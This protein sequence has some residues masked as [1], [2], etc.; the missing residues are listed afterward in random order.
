MSETISSGYRVPVELLTTGDEVYAGI[1]A[2]KLHIESID[3]TDGRFRKAVILKDGRAIET[4]LPAGASY[5]V[6][7]QQ[8]YEEITAR[9]L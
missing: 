4:S 7:T 1:G 5:L 6:A 2:P 9:G 3:Q 8:E